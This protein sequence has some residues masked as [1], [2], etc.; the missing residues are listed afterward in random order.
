MEQ[1]INPAGRA[2]NVISAGVTLVFNVTS[3]SVG[4]E[5]RLNPIPTLLLVTVVKMRIRRLVTQ[6]YRFVSWV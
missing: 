6:R 4:M 1:Q 5:W 3:S 2:F